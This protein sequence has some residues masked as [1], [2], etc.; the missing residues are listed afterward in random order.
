M[1]TRYIEEEGT[2]GEGE[3]QQQGEHAKNQ[4]QNHTHKGVWADKPF[5]SLHLTMV[6]DIVSTKMSRNYNGWHDWY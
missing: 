6:A 3:R 1:D 5:Q 2:E 4:I